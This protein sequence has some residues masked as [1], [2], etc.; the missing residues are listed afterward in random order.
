M[1]LLGGKVAIVDDAR[2]DGSQSR[3]ELAREL[4]SGSAGRDDSLLRRA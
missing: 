3:D 1:G 4:N 2:S